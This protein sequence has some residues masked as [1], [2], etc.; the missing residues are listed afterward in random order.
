MLYD[1]YGFIKLFHESSSQLFFACNTKEFFNLLFFSS[2]SAS[3]SHVLHKRKVYTINMVYVLTN[4]F[5]ST[6]TTTYD[7]ARRCGTLLGSCFMAIKNKYHIS[8][9]FY[10]IYLQIIQTISE[11]SLV[12]YILN[13]EINFFRRPRY[14][15]YRY[16]AYKI[17]WQWLRVP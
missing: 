13:L 9:L 8:Q 14:S 5:L 2:V 11:F 15:A 7:V 10:R 4:C 6:T 16:S 12:L 1:F 3:I 17:R